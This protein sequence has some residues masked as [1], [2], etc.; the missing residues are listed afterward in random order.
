M[1]RHRAFFGSSVR[2]PELDAHR[3]EVPV[4]RPDEHPK[5]VGHNCGDGVHDSDAQVRKPVR[6]GRA[7]NPRDRQERIRAPYRPGQPSSAGKIAVVL[8]ACVPHSAALSGGCN[9]QLSR[10]RSKT[11]P[12]QIFFQRRVHDGRDRRGSLLPANVRVQTEPDLVADGDRCPPH[13][14]RI[15]PV[16]PFRD[17]MANAK[18]G[19]SSSGVGIRNPERAV[20]TQIRTEQAEAW[21]S[22]VSFG[23]RLYRAQAACRVLDSSSAV[24]SGVSRIR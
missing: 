17:P 14:H 4:K 20:R 3:R 5:L 24:C 8:D 10:S 9:P 11:S 16:S 2:P 7:T 15:A 6:P 12:C 18:T 19:R 1:P 22:R 21:R 13:A 23:P